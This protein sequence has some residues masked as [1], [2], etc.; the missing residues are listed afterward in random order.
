[1]LAYTL[2]AFNKAPLCLTLSHPDPPHPHQVVLMLKSSDRVAH[3]LDLLMERVRSGQAPAHASAQQQ[4][5]A[6][7]TQNASS[8]PAMPQAETSSSDA[9]PTSAA[10]TPADS[11]STSTSTSGVQPVLV[12]RKHY[13]LRPEREFRCFVSGRAVVAVSQRD[14][15]QHFPQLSEDVPRIRSLLEAFHARHVQGKFP[16]TDCKYGREKT[17][18]CLLCAMQMVPTSCVLLG[19]CISLADLLW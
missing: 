1:M 12:L 9:P 14:P 17:C 11:T 5:Q 16:L 13:D 19:A 4:A 7:T 10:T 8:Q 18:W 3:D 15:S 6:D 2:I